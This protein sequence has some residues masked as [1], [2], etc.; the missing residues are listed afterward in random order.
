MKNMFLAAL[1]IVFFSCVSEKDKTDCHNAVTI[2]NKSNSVIYF[3]GRDSNSQI[4]YNPLKSGE[5][6]KIVPGATKDDIFGKDRGCYED[7]FTENNNK[8]YYLL[9]DEQVLLNE[10]WDSIVKYDK[11]L[12][13]FSFTLKEM[14][15]ANWEII[16]DGN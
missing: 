12:K 10:P 1:S 7:L 4:S 2:Q 8:L 14:Q 13:R 6:F 11:V 16:Y 3:G 15:D 9:Y 5:Y